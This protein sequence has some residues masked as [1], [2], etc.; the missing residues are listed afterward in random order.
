MWISFVFL[1]NSCGL[2]AETVEII[3]ITEVLL[4]MLHSICRICSNR[5]LGEFSRFSILIFCHSGRAGEASC[6][7][8]V[9]LF[10][11]LIAECLVDFRIIVEFSERVS[12]S[13]S[14]NFSLLILDFLSRF[15]S[16][17]TVSVTLFFD[18]SLLFWAQNWKNEF[19]P[20]IRVSGTLPITRKA[21]QKH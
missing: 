11:A 7:D 12:I 21:C 5:I 15:S 14:S 9:D 18:E 10:V 2:L 6:S 1:W 8:L 17:G 16:F 20:K 13:I 4:R 3:E 19:E